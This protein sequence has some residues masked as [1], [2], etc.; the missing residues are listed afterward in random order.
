MSDENSVRGFKS[1]IKHPRALAFL[2]VLFVPTPAAADA[3]DEAVSQDAFLLN[4]SAALASH[5]IDVTT[6]LNARDVVR[7]RIRN[8]RLGRFPDL[9]LDRLADSA[10]IA[11]WEAAFGESEL[12]GLAVIADAEAIDASAEEYLRAGWKAQATSACLSHSTKMIWSRR[13]S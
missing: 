7:Q 2:A 6:N 13:R 9:P 3:L 12:G 5:D 1:F 8:V 10:E 4:L 11:N